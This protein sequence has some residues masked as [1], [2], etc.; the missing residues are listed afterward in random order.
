[1]VKPWVEL[2]FR[3]PRKTI[4]EI[5]RGDDTDEFIT[6]TDDKATFSTDH[7]LRGVFDRGHRFF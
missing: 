3:T 4:D 7:R 2:R 5:G 1:L 6:S